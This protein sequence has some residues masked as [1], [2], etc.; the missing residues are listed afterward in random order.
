MKTFYIILI[1]FFSFTIY[2]CA[3]KSDTSSTT[4]TNT[5]IEGTWKSPCYSSSGGYYL[6]VTNTVSGTSLVQDYDYHSDSS[7][8]SDN[9]TMK[10]TYGSYSEGVAM[11][12]D[13]YGSSGGSG[14]RFTMTLSTVTE[15]PQTSAEV[16]WYN[17][18]SFCG[19]SD[20]ALNTAHDTTGKTCGGSPRWS[21]NTTIYGLY[22]LDG[23]SLFIEDS[24][25]SY[26]SSVDTGANDTL[27]KQ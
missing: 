14:K 27:T 25:S 20:W 11:V 4:T 26:P 2:S 18:S 1:L 7:C 24:S 22:L 17:T 21:A 3:K 16:T 13:S 6:T 23:N 19:D 5:E 12:F 8:S 10:Y 15:T 9:Y